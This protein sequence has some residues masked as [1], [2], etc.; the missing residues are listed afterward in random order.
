LGVGGEQGERPKGLFEKSPSGLPK[1][2]QKEYSYF[3]MLF[4]IF[5]VLRALQTS[6]QANLPPSKARMFSK[7]SKLPEAAPPHPHK[8]QL[9]LPSFID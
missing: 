3:L 5:G 8:H 9:V 7:S 2:L 1:N 4:E 6:S